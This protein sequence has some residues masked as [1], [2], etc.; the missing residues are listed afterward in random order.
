MWVAVAERWL[1]LR[2]AV[3]TVLLLAGRHQISVF[4]RV[5]VVVVHTSM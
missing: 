1:L 3:L 5:V 2:A 4:R